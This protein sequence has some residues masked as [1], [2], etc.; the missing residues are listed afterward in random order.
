MTFSSFLIDDLEALP[1]LIPID[2]VSAREFKHTK[3]TKKLVLK[4]L[5]RFFLIC[6][7]EAM[8]FLQT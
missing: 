7:L 3:S 1:I 2:N 6:I 8:N 5:R 4:N